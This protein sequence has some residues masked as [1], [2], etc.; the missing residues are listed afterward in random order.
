MKKILFTIG[1]SALLVACANRSNEEVTPVNWNTEVTVL[2]PKD[3]ILQPDEEREALQSFKEGA[4][5]AEKA[6]AGAYMEWLAK[7]LRKE[8]RSTGIQVKE[9][10]GQ[11][12]L[13]IPSHVAFG[14]YQTSLQGNFRGALSSIANLLK[15]YDQTMIQIIGYTDDVG[16]VLANQQLSVQRAEKIGAF[17]REQEIAAERIFSN[18]VGP[19]NPVANNATTAGREQNN[20]VE[21]TIISLQ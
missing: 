4:S 6:K 2:S 5:A 14:N 10:A 7:R 16:S 18:G 19:D 21:I 12:D 3:V 9:V 11:I 17:L 8:L 1:I 13:I 20:R 15:E